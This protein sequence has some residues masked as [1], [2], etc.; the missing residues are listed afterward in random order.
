MHSN[1]VNFEDFEVMSR[2]FFWLNSAAFDADIDFYL[3]HMDIFRSHARFKISLS[4][5]SEQ[6]FFDYYQ[7]KSMLKYWYI[8]NTNLNSN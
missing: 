8:R 5:I 4:S 7:S 3:Q 6:I 2:D 1:A